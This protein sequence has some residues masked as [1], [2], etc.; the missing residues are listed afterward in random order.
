MMPKKLSKS[1]PR[2]AELSVKEYAR[3]NH[4]REGLNRWRNAPPGIP[5][6]MAVEFEAAI[7][8]GKTISDLTNPVDGVLFA[9]AGFWLRTENRTWH[10]QEAIQQ[11]LPIDRQI[12]PAIGRRARIS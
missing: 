11:S 6:D 1:R 5:N 4:I 9:K 12:R 2:P 3:R 7:K 10:I 8:A